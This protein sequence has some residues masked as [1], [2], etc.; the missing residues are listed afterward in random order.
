MEK[1][2]IIPSD[3]TIF[4]IIF[5]WPIYAIGLESLALCALGP[6]CTIGIQQLLTTCSFFL[7]GS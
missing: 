1:K 7:G 4:I 5:S 6:L 3:I 2:K